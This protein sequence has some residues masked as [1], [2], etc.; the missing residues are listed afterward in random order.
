MYRIVLD[1]DPG[2]DDA[3]AL[4]LAVASPELH[5]EAITTVSGNVHV[6]STTYNALALLEIAG[7]SDIIVARGCSRPLV[8]S[9]INA[10]YF[11]GANG[12][13]EVALPPPRCRVVEQHAA[14]LIIER[15]MDNPG[16]IT[17][18]AIGPLT[19]IATAL[20]NEPRIAKAV[21]EVVI[22]GGALRVKGN[23]TPS[24]E[25]NI[26]ADPH[27]A[28]LVLHAGWPIRLI[29]LD[30]TQQVQLREEHLI[31]FQQSNSAVLALIP[32][33]INYYFK[34]F[35]VEHGI[36]TFAM[37]DPLC[38]AAV[39]QPGFIHWEPAYVTIELNGTYTLGETVAYFDDYDIPSPHSPNVRVAVSVE[40]D[41]FL[42]WY[43]D[44]MINSSL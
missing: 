34:H 42:Q 10:A 35:A 32:K 18:V 2:L 16:E 25:F 40:G 5:I 3:L 7:R 12:V 38:L 29:P 6:D 20:Q 15:V 14:N 27:A 4:F 21:R 39:F 43:L 8:R 1:T 30:V 36:D 37:H 11:H 24:A 19:N 22:M 26:L 44:R 41:R 9:P 31:P 28:D 17:L 13:G 23:V 33:M